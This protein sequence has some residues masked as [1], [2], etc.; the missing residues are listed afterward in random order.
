[1]K[2]FLSTIL[3][4]SMVVAM[5]TVGASATYL[6]DANH[7]T[8]DTAG[9]S[10]TAG[11]VATDYSKGDE[12]GSV[13][14]PVYIQT[15]SDDKTTHVYAVSY[16]VT[17]LSFTYNGS[18]S[19][20]WNPETLKYETSTSGTW[21]TASQDIT[22]TNYSDLAIKVTPSNTTPI[23]SGVTVT[24]GSALELASAFDGDAAAAGTAKSGTINVSVSGTP[25]ASYTNKTELTKVTLTIA[26]NR[27]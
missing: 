14:I 15:T 13:E 3:S 5:L 25:S 16:D 1:M 17:E 20:I 2:K 24:L 9:N 4:L 12:I 8:A 21:A 7:V 6:E 27:A 22:V 11:I 26:D 10:N 19:T 23:D 18:S